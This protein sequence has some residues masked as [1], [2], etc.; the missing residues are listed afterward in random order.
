MGKTY[1]GLYQIS[2]M[3]RFVKIVYRN[4][5]AVKCFREKFNQRVLNTAVQRCNKTTKPTFGSRYS[6]MDQIKFVEDSL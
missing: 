4:V 1:L 2:L 5:F 3:E 6:E